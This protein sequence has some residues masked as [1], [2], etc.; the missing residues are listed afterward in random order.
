MILLGCLAAA[1]PATR[2]APWRA[3]DPVTAASGLRP[4]DAEQAGGASSYLESVRGTPVSASWTAAR[5]GA[6]LAGAGDDL[7]A[8]LGATG[9]LE[10]PDTTA[11][12]LVGVAEGDPEEVF[13]TETRGSS[14][15]FA[16][17]GTRTPRRATG[18]LWSIPALGAFVGGLLLLLRRR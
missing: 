12:Q 18:G 15:G 1:T 5:V 4:G 8:V 16:D 9:S 13:R 11:P 2:A 6:G 7:W 14:P 10:T 3:D 17:T